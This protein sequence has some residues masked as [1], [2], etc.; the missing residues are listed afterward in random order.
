VCEA[1]HTR[2]QQGVDSTRAPM[3]NIFGVSSICVFLEMV[4]SV[5]LHN[6]NPVVVSIRR[7]AALARKTLN[8]V[9]CVFI[10]VQDYKPSLRHSPVESKALTVF[11]EQVFVGVESIGYLYHLRVAR[12]CNL[13]SGNTVDAVRSVARCQP[14]HFDFAPGAHMRRVV[15][16]RIE[17]PRICHETPRSDP[18][19]VTVSVIQVSDAQEVSC[20]VSDHS[21]STNRA[22]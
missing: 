6:R 15:L 1:C 11:N 9:I 4:L 21:D 19:T 5:R 13:G 3:E 22:T 12:V 18:V 14:T 20:L 7:P 16:T 2:R 17:A 8:V 10:N